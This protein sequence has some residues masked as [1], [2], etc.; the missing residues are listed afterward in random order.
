[1]DYQDMDEESRERLKKQQVE[2][3]TKKRYSSSFMILASLFMILET[4]IIMFASFVLAAL[5]IFKVFNMAESSAGGTVYSIVMV[6]I[7][8]GGLVTGF[9]IYTK[10]VRWA[11][12]KFKL[13]EK[14]S[15]DVLLHYFKKEEL[16]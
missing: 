10:S 2:Y 7:F 13:K 15:D 5:L 1:M 8:I 3:R 16:N 6:L 12:I 4:V 14:L 9:L 11:I